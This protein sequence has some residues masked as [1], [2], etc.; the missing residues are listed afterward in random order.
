LNN[1]P[2]NENKKKCAKDLVIK[3]ERAQLK[4][5]KRGGVKTGKAEEKQRKAGI[6]NHTDEDGVVKQNSKHRHK[7]KSSWGSEERGGSGISGGSAGG[8]A[9]RIEKKRIG[10]RSRTLQEGAAP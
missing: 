7:E 1:A 3:P 5:E 2:G 10:G 4:R 8:K 6:V 9:R